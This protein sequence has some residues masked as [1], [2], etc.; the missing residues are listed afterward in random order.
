MRRTSPCEPRWMPIFPAER[1]AGHLSPHIWQ[2]DWLISVCWVSGLKSQRSQA[3]AATQPLFTRAN[4]TN[5]HL[6]FGKKIKMF[7][8]D[9]YWSVDGFVKQLCESSL[10]QLVIG[11]GAP[12][13]KRICMGKKFIK[14][15]SSCILAFRRITGNLVFTFQTHLGGWTVLSQKIHLRTNSLIANF[16]SLWCLKECCRFLLHSREY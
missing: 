7:I 12:V 3:T 4:K 8:L 13:K 9:F 10:L 16:F 2:M 5:N 15:N 14:K 6:L 11:V 1:E